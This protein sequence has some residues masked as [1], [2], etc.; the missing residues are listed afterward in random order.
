[1]TEGERDTHRMTRERETETDKDRQTDTETE[2]GKKTERVKI[3][4][5]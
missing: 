4:F 3:A 2:T 1:M 5:G